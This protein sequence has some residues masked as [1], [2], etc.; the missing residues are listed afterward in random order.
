MG[1]AFGPGGTPYQ[2][3]YGTIYGSSMV[4]GGSN[5]Q[6]EIGTNHSGLD[7]TLTRGNVY[8]RASYS[9]TPQTSVY[10]T[11]LFAQSH[12]S[13]VGTWQ[14][15]RDG[16]ITIQ[17]D[18][19]FLAASVKT[20]CANNGITNFSFGTYNNDIANATGG[21]KVVTDRTLNRFTLGTE[22]TLDAVGS[23]WAWNVH[24]EHGFNDSTD[25]TPNTIITPY[26]AAAIDAVAGPNGS[27]ICRS[28][29]ARAN[30]CVPINLFGTGVSSPDAINYVLGEPTLYTQNRE[31]A[32]GAS[33]NGTPFS[34][35]AGKV[36]LAA[37]VEYR[38]EAFTQQADCM[39]Y[40]NCPTTANPAGN[41]LLSNTVA[42]YYAGNFHPSS[43]SFHVSE[44]FLE[45]DVPV[46]KDP[47]WGRRRS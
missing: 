1:I 19:A 37:G 44:V 28:A 43:G 17:C 35:W 31:E 25:R 6:S 20:A 10:A 33:I 2:Y 15:Y 5:Q 3:Q 26:Y 45:V 8:L 32:F 29:V 14:M 18:N 11:Y 21:L 47:E 40:S 7:Q 13:D 36:S 39:S 4:G 38:E 12:T 23:E 30:G 41:P 24:G 46:L 34:T 22:G 27:I 9:I 42:N 16:N